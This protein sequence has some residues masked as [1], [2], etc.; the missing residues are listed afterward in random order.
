MFLL[1]HNVQQWH[2]LP[3][4][5]TGNLYSIEITTSHFKF[6]YQQNLYWA[7]NTY[8][9][10]KCTCRPTGTNYTV[11]VYQSDMTANRYQ[12]HHIDRSYCPDRVNHGTIY[13]LLN[14]FSL[15]LYPATVLN[16]SHCGL[17]TPRGVIK[18]GEHWF[19]K[20]LMP[21]GFPE[22]PLMNYQERSCGSPEKNVKEMAQRNIER[23]TA[24]NLFHDLNLS[25]GKWVI[26]P[27]W[28]W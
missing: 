22:Q 25:N 21:A 8:R 20:V 6:F 28:C 15:A 2:S 18:L 10:I 7:Y 26:F 11:Y 5:Q 3:T 23:N 1:I 27:I 14:W 4:N 12:P 16:S 17:V 24:H 19:G 9:Y 13:V